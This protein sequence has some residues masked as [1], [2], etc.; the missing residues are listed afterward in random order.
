MT[1]EDERIARPMKMGMTMIC[2]N[3]QNRQFANTE[4]GAPLQSQWSWFISTPSF[5]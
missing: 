1:N 2:W 4:S 5:A 3:L